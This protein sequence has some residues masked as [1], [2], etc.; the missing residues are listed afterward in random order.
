MKLWSSF[1]FSI[2]LVILNFSVFFYRTLT[3]TSFLKQSNVT[4]YFILNFNTLTQKKM[5]T[6][7]LRKNSW[8]YYIFLH[9]ISPGSRELWFDIERFR[10][11]SLFESRHLDSNNVIWHDFPWLID[12]GRWTLFKPQST[13]EATTQHLQKLLWPVCTVIKRNNSTVAITKAMI[14]VRVGWNNPRE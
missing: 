11:K 6:I 13:Q 7:K 8:K 12:I 4:M 1:F 9:L 10:I 2:N 5:V 3:L 14:T